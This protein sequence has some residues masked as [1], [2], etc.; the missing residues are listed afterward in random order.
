M[1]LGK[2][3][4]RAGQGSAEFIMIFAV[5]LVIMLVFMS[6]SATRLT[7]I[8]VQK[9]FEDAHATVANLAE[10]ADSV[11][12][13]G[14]GA[15]R[16]VTITI[17]GNANLNTNHSYIG[18]P[19][20]NPNASST[21]INLDLNGTDVFAITRA[22]ISGAFPSSFGTYAMKVVSRGSSV[23]IYPSLIELNGNSFSFSMG[24]PDSRS[25]TLKVYAVSS[26]TTRVNVTNDWGFSP[27]VNLTISSSNFV[28]SPSGSILSISASSGAGSS[29]VYSSQLTFYANASGAN[30]TITVPVTVFVN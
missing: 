22:P 12:A 21:S 20:N 2:T 18:R 14:E 6:L 11:Y 4:A 10:A 5:S 26:Q 13:Q 3:C 25:A 1:R 15:S 24:N 9:N 30:E 17:P 23:G 16:T 29:G 19:S 8:N 28:A 27:G 7:D